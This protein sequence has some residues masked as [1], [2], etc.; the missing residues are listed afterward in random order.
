MELKIITVIAASAIAGALFLVWTIVQVWQRTGDPSVK[1]NLAQLLYFLDEQ[2][3]NIEIPNKR[4]QAVMAI[5]AL[6]G[7][8]RVWIPMVLIGLSLDLLVKL[9]RRT[10]IPD[11]HKT[12]RGSDMVPD[13]EDKEGSL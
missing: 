8:K 11:L 9:I 1:E 5:Q 12:N 3:D 2:C 6:L 4:T 7:W 10:G 13:P